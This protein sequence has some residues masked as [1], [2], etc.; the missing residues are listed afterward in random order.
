M[1]DERDPELGVEGLEGV[2]PEYWL[3]V[4][5]GLEAAVALVEASSETVG[6]VLSSYPILALPEFPAAIKA[7]GQQQEDPRTSEACRGT[8]EFLRTLQLQ[9]RDNDAPWYA[10]W[11]YNCATD[12]EQEYR[13]DPQ[14][15]LW[16]SIELFQVARTLFAPDSPN[17]AL[18]LL[19]EGNA[20][21]DLA[22]LGVE[23]RENLGAAIR[24]YQQARTLFAPDGPDCA[25]C[26]MNEGTA[27]SRLAEL[28]VEP[29]ENLGAAIRLYQQAR[30]LFAPDSPDLALCLR[31]EGAAR[32]GLAELGME[33][34]EN[35]EAAESL[36]VEAGQAF[37][38]LGSHLN[39]IGAY[40][41]LAHMAKSQ[42][43][44]EKARKAYE[45]AVEV[46]ERVRSSMR[47]LRHQQA[48][49]EQNIGLYK[50]MVGTCLRLGR[51]DEALEYV[52]RGRSRVLLDLIHLEDQ[53][54]HNVDAATA[55][56][57]RQL[58]R[59][60]EDNEA[61]MSQEDGTRAGGDHARER[62]AW[63]SQLQKV[64]A[65]RNA[66]DTLEREIRVRDPDFFATARPLN[67]KEM[68]DL[69][70]GLDRTLVLLWV[71]S[72]QARAFLVPPSGQVDS[73]PLEGVNDAVVREWMLGPAD[74]PTPS[75]WMGT[76]LRFRAGELN[77]AAWKDQIQQTV[78]TI[79]G[80]LMAPVRRW[81]RDHGQER[82]ALVVAGPLGLLPLH[83]A[84]WEEGGR[85]RY[86]L[87]ELD[88]VYAP[89]A[90]VL[91]RCYERPRDAWSPVL[92]VVNPNRDDPDPRLALPFSEWEGAN[93]EKVVTPRGAF[94]GDLL[95][96][97]AKVDNVLGALPD[98]PVAH[99]ACHGSWDFLEPLKSHLLLA[100]G[101]LTLA[102]LLR[103]VRLARGRLVVLSACES[104]TGFAPGSVGEEYL[105]LPAGFILAGAKSVVGS[106]WSVSD[107]PTALLMVAFY[108]RLL[109]GLGL[110]QA[111]REAQNWLRG[112]S[113]EQAE[114]LVAESGLGRRDV[115]AYRGW[116]ARQGEAPYNHSY[117]WAAFAVFGSPQPV[118][119][120]E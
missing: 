100:D 3:G 61:Q 118:V 80:P 52:E 83:A 113:R 88:I 24:L 93:I 70:R 55:D 102:D 79:D 46:L 59:A 18:C 38:T 65:T 31:V 4:C 110:P 2:P 82:V 117:Y 64:T 60:V 35:L 68:I 20:R 95:G 75:G 91:R 78:R 26:L 45:Q 112:L 22:G 63:A 34:R 54:P 94:R 44:W 84:C 81:L 42:G 120:S 49:M 73:L 47:L 119:R 108:R 8:A 105:G 56:R 62:T 58:R 27:R 11:F 96:P 92:G 41:N 103:Q 10:G 57:Y 48:W 77:L 29:G 72:D 14:V 111:L 86:L 69:A 1:A 74:D 67:R 98:H 33:P 39:A 106:L 30:P 6:E 28:G 116:L 17:F 97:R 109:A 9:I 21:R 101:V 114:D 90:W 71:G 99:F 37:L 107:W 40:G 50:G 43:R 12:L 15:N 104:G 7:L 85:P 16:R 25:R 87:D 89:S 115:E 19:N 13:Q 5:R 23:P 53:V 51:L 36:Y 76:Y 32:W 66:L